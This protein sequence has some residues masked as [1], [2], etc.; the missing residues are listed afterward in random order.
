MRYA[1]SH[2]GLTPINGLGILPSYQY[3]EDPAVNFTKI[4][5]HVQFPP[6]M[7]QTTPQPA[8]PYYQGPMGTEGEGPTSKPLGFTNPL[9]SLTTATKVALGIAVAAG[10][11]F[12]Y[13]H[14]GK[15]RR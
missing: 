1:R 15:R 5:P 2:H 4:N 11:W 6:G 3:S 9:S 14:F 8:Y 7:Y 12:A 10:G 13:R